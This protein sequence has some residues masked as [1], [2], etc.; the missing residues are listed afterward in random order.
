MLCA[1]IT[2]IGYTYYRYMIQRDFLVHVQVECNPVVESCFAAPCEVSGV[3]DACVTTDSGDS[4]MYYKYLLKKAYLFP[5]CDPQSE[6]CAYPTC[7]GDK[8]CTTIVCNEETV[9]DGTYCTQ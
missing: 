1:G 4:V 8:S 2:S 6:D 3:A 7:E 9:E 5:D